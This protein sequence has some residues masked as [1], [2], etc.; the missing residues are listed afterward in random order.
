M[1]ANLALFSE[2][3]NQFANIRF[4]DIVKVPVASTVLS[5]NVMICI[6]LQICVGWKES[7]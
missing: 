1:V 7:T 4:G 2:I 6:V 3:A 5:Q